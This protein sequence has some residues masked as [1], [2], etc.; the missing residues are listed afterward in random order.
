MQHLAVIMDGNGRWAEK[1]NLQRSDGHV[2]GAKALVKA[3]SDFSSLPFNVMTVYAFST[4]NNSRN[5]E[6]VSNILG[7]IA[8]F[9][10][11]EIIPVA[12]ENHIKIAF[13]GDRENLTIEV[14]NAMLETEEATKE[15]A[16]KTLIIAINYG[17]VDEVC[18][19]MNKIKAKNLEIN[20]Y[21]LYE[22]LD[23]VGYPLPDVVLRYGGYKR[24]S[25]FLPL[26]T[27][28]SELMFID[29]FWPDYSVGD[30]L[31]VI[32]KYRTIKRNFGGDDA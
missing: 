18:R 32:E 8:Y 30:F 13:I 4:E 10:K 25:N 21:T 5:N 6:E 12:R 1:K 27:V 20:Q 16:T 22:N 24:L 28:Y 7:V 15:F 23:T 3:L 29:K 11:K 9:L 31:E 19:A 26:Q 2:A 17:G 14:K